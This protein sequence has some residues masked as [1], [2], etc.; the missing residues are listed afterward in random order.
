MQTVIGSE[1]TDYTF[2]NHNGGLCSITQ[3]GETEDLKNAI[4]IAMDK[5]IPCFNVIN[6]VES[7][8]A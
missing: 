7:H 1:V 5:G 2:P 6:K 4:R 3:S 8:I